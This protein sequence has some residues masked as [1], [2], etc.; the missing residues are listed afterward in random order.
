MTSPTHPDKCKNTDS[1]LYV[2]CKHCD[3]F[4]DDNDLPSDLSGA[5]LERFARFI[6]LNS[7]EKDHDHEAEPGAR[8]QTLREWKQERPDLFVRFPDGKIGPNSEYFTH[9]L[10]DA[11]EGEEEQ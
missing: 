11:R 8:M 7:G 5:E 4:V 10:E 6:H 9:S 2:I 1:Q 3:H